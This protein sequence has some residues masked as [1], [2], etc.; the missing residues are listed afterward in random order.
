MP[1]F[2]YQILGDMDLFGFYPIFV[3]GTV[4]DFIQEGNLG[5]DWDIEVAHDNINFNENLWQEFGKTLSQKGRVDFLSYKVIRLSLFDHQIEFS[6]PRKE[7]FVQELAQGGHKNFN[8]EFDFKMPFDDAVKRRDFT[9][10]A[11]GVRFKSK[12]L[13]FLDPLN[14][15]KHLEQKILY[16]AGDNFS[17]DPVRFLRAIRFSVKYKMQISS[18]LQKHLQTMPLDQITPSYLWSELIKSK[19]PLAF[20]RSILDWSVQHPELNLPVDSELSKK[21]QEIET[22]LFDPYLHES[23]MLA[24]EWAGISSRSWQKYFSLASDLPIKLAR[25]TEHSKKLSSIQP[26][27]FQ[28]KF[29]EIQ[30]RLEFLILV[31][32]YSTTKQ[33]LQKNSNVPLLKIIGQELSIWLPIFDHQTSK[34]LE[35]IGPEQRSKYQVWDLCQKL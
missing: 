2:F 19:A 26:Q 32:W 3:G 35:H 8:A 16:P 33:I 29:E 10:N 11:M 30:E 1:D 5:A 4:R 34:E 20:Y 7:H 23:W 21:Y 17:K 25:W 18:E 14:G 22:K 13:D 24:L 12:E 15:L 6:P 27:E 28:Y 9:V 31:D